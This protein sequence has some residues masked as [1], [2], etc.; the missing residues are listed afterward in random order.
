VST[1]LSKSNSGTQSGARPSA[2]VELTPE[3]VLAAALPGKN[4]APVYAFESL[5]AGALLPG[6]GEPNVRAPETLAEAI[7]SALDAV[8][9]RTSSVSVV[10]PDTA[11]RVFVL[12]FDTLPARAAEAIAVL[13]FRM[14]KMVP[15][16]VEHAGIS[17]QILSE[18]K[19]ECRVLVA[20]MPSAILA[21]YE[22]TVRE[23]G[24]EPGA[25]IP[26]GLAALAALDS[27]EP[28]LTAC[29]SRSALTTAIT[30]GNDL[31]LYRTLDLP[32]EPEARIA[33]VQRG[34]AVAAAYYEDKLAGRPQK[35]YFAGNGNAAEFTRWI[36]D[37]EFSV[38]D[39]A[40]RPETGAAS[41]MGSVSFA[42]IAGA[43]AGAA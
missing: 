8:S 15:F 33:E 10:I 13:R 18:N 5:S 37:S 3:G 17:Y 1:I 29:L 14:R 26:S 25:V 27:V 16:D 42:G 34:V 11:V 30:N 22:A 2:A 4:H 20:I 32:D 9:P 31:L 23:A 39:L 38:V 21:E 40:P 6:I 43:L 12:D 36:G 35:L 28:V 19:N 41:A 7:R 24:Y